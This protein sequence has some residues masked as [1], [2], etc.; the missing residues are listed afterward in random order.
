MGCSLLLWLALNVAN[1][2]SVGWESV[3][4]D[5]VPGVVSIQVTAVRSFDTENAGA[6]QGTGFVVD[7][8]RGIILTNRH[9]VHTGPV[10]AEAV[11]LDDSEVKLHAIYRDPVH[12]F[13]FY[14]M[15]PAEMPPGTPALV[16]A[17]EA[18][19]AQREIR[20]VGNDAGEKV[21]ILDGTLARL[22]RNAPFYGAN[23]Y[24]D[25]N[26]FYYQAASNTSGGSSGSPVVDQSGR[27]VALNAGGKVQAASSYYLPLERVNRALKK[28][29]A[30]EPVTRGTLQTIW[31]YTSMDEVRRL[32]LPPEIIDEVRAADPEGTGMLVVTEVVPGGPAEG[33]LRAGDVL[34][35]VEGALVTRFVPL[36]EQLDSSVGGAVRL[37]VFRGGA[38]LE[39]ELTVQDLHGISPSAYTE[40][41]RGVFHEVSYQTARNHAISAKGAYLALSGYMFGNAGVPEGAVITAV[42]GAAV[43]SAAELRRALE[44][45]SDGQRFRVRYFH[46]EEPRREIETAVVMDRAWFPM[47]TCFRDASGAWPCEESPAPPAGEVAD[48][49]VF[50]PLQAEEKLAQRVA[51]SLVMVSFD[52]PVPSAGM[53]DFH[54]VGVGAVV[55]AAAG[56]VVVDRDTVPVAAGDISLVFG[57]TVRVPGTLRYLHP[58]HNLAVIQFDPALMPDSTL[59]ALD[60]HEAPLEAGDPV[61]LVG[62]DQTFQV[63]SKKTTVEGREPFVSNPSTTPKFRDANLDVVDLVS[64]V[65][66]L[67]GVLVDKRGRMLGSWA[68]FVDPRDGDRGF[69]GVPVRYILPI[70]E[71]LREGKMPV[72]RDLGAELAP[73]N[74][75]DARDRGL[76]DERVA[77]VVAAEPLRRRV[78]EVVRIS[79]GTPAR[80]LLREGDILLELDGHLVTRLS[81]IEE[82]SE[83]DEVHLTVLRDGEELQ[84]TVPTLL[85]DGRGV[86]R[87]VS[88]AGMQLH[89]PH[90]EVAAA[91]GENADGVYVAWMWY[92]SPAARYEIRP[93]RRIVAVND[94]PTPDLDAFLAAVAPL[95]DS[96]PV[97]L[98]M[99]DME[100]REWVRTLK[101][102][103]QYWPTQVYTR[104]G[105]KWQRAAKF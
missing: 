41:S 29:Q 93:V 35:R 1:A 12:D 22:D 102:D 17:P 31:E 87:M 71:P 70:L 47:Q 4:A 101:L 8:E 21:S 9:M 10:L 52:I 3:L 28:L 18:A 94:V 62:L 45:I 77:Q 27:V 92:G 59:T 105:G 42:D 11:F 61:W 63:V 15:D 2:E 60:L 49:G 65:S 44:G 91:T 26:T 97:R 34:A 84:L 51:Q 20:V 58:T 23:T 30:G 100:G 5:V 73:V 54:F 89:A 66:S 24:N 76:S 85:A 88:W 40:I 46:V 33:K 86:D 7:R 79:G 13:G 50:M 96:S 81:E 43:E 53:R 38:P 74:A 82:V 99:L 103:L 37:Q 6:S 83:Q 36:E 75:V 78:L 39:L 55:D 69:H 56:L 72:Y 95:G 16:L 19:K 68:S 32:G 104:E 80:G 67:G 98:R 64:T 48:G 14:Q 25:F 90:R 57:G